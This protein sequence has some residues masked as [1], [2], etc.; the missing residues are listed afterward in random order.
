[1]ENS[2]K[3]VAT[4]EDAIAQFVGEQYMEWVMTY[5]DNQVEAWE[6][7][8][9]IASSAPKPEK[10]KKLLMQRYLASQAFNGGVDGDPGFLGFAIAN[11]SESSDPEAESALELLQQKK[12]LLA[13]EG[14][15]TM[16]KWKKL[17]MAVGFGEE[18]IKRTDP[19]EPTRN[20]IAELSDVYSNAEWP[21]TMAAFIVHEKLE[22]LEFPAITGM[23]KNSLTISD[24][25]LQVLIGDKS[26]A[27]TITEARHIL[28]KSVVDQ[29]GKELIF[30]GMKRQLEARKDFLEALSKYLYE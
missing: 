22:V 10:I 2:I 28:E 30:D 5:L 29:E 9:L 21:T 26:D 17:L 4:P 20:Y 24:D 23:L 6:S 1:M 15:L 7:L 12:Q 11:L 27:K 16:A 13:G 8:R 25:D 14:N 19:K 3:P 18:E